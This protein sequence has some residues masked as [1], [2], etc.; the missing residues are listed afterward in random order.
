MEDE[1][2]NVCSTVEGEGCFKTY[3]QCLLAVCDSD[4]LIFSLAKDSCTL[5]CGST[6]ATVC[7]AASH[8]APVGA[9][10]I[11]VAALIAVIGARA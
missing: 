1:V 7:D 5:V 4:D 10:L 11:A 2:N 3:M 6:E 8:D 9:V